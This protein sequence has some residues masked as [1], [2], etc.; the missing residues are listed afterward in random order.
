MRVLYIY[1]E[2]SII[3]VFGFTVHFLM[4]GVDADDGAVQ[5]R[6]LVERTRML[7]EVELCTSFLPPASPSP[8]L[9]V[10]ISHL[11]STVQY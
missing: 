9:R 4:S 8:F 6:V 1:L 10:S 2:I 3:K 11:S 5:S 7:R